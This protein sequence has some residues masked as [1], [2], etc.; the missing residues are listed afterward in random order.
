MAIISSTDSNFTDKNIQLGASYS[1]Y[2]ISIDKNGIE[3][4]KS[5]EV[6]IFISSQR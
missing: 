6:G 4:G 1:Y 3:G 2:L 5:A